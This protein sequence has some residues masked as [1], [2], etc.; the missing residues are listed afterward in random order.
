M[1]LVEDGFTLTVYIR[2]ETAALKM[3]GIRVVCREG[4]FGPDCGCSPHNDSTGHFTCATDG[5]KVCLRGYQDPE[6]NCIAEA[7]TSTT[8]EETTATGNTHVAVSATGSSP[9][10]A[11]ASIAVGGSAGGF[12]LL[13]IVLVI[14]VVLLSQ[15]TRRRRTRRVDSHISKY[16][17]MSCMC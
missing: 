12:I 2:T 3:E 17:T 6:T 9:P 16:N 5:T 10:F 14:F 7:P 1:N 15:Y 8:V 4:Y 11:I 13:L